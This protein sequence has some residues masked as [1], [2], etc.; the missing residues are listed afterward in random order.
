MGIELLKIYEKS[1]FVSQN[2]WGYNSSYSTCSNL[3]KTIITISRNGSS[4]FANVSSFLS[5]GQGVLTEAVI[6]WRWHEKP[7]ELF[8]P[9]L[10]FEGKNNSGS[11][12]CFHI[13][14]NTEISIDLWWVEPCL[15][16]NY[17]EFYVL[18]NSKNNLIDTWLWDKFSV[19]W[20]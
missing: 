3:L 9:P 7:L 6:S 10:L 16:C 8:L 15:P 18:P 2:I 1:C 13:D 19:F 20:Q 11:G 17:C 12:Y 5:R 4:N 14:G